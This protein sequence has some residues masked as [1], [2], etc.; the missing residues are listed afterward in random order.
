MG[1]LEVISQVFTE[2]PSKDT[3]NTPLR[4]SCHVQ[5]SFTRA[6]NRSAT[7][8]I[9]VSKYRDSNDFRLTICI[10]QPVAPPILLRAPASSIHRAFESILGIRPVLSHLWR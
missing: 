8:L 4:Y 1:E 2:K 10:Q 7:L 9:N 5:R 3:N 6:E